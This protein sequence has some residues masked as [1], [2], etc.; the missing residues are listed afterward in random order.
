MR[1]V[2]MIAREWPYAE[3]MISVDVYEG[4]LVGFLA[5]SKKNRKPDQRD[6]RFALKAGPV[7]SPCWR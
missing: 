5:P 1:Q 3:R 2:W 4:R 6:T 7:Q